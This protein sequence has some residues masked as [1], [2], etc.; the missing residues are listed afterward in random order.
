MHCVPELKFLIM[1]AFNEGSRGTR[2]AR[3]LVLSAFQMAYEWRPRAG[4]YNIRRADHP[5][6]IDPLQSDPAPESLYG[7][8]FS[9]EMKRG[10][11]IQFL[12]LPVV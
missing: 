8:L 2:I 5:T 1:M 9:C 11:R 6:S 7:I 4:L 3:L 10:E 12:K